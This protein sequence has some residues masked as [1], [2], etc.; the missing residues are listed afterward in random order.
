M[1]RIAFLLTVIYLVSCNYRRA[2]HEEPYDFMVTKAILENYESKYNQPPWIHFELSIVNRSDSTEVVLGG[3]DNLYLLDERSRPL[4]T[5]TFSEFALI[6]RPDS[7]LSMSLMG[8]LVPVPSQKD[9]E[10]LLKSNLLYTQIY[11]SAF[12]D[13]VINKLLIEGELQN[14]EKIKVVNR[15]ET[16]KSELFEYYIK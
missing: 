4:D 11:D 6:V 13:S 9:I 3:I 10:K 7:I 15:F 2:N 8:I 5:I 12:E 16:H 1:K 14:N